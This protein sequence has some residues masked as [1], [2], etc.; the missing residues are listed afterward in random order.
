MS[1][2]TIKKT[3]LLPVL[4]L[5]ILTAC[6]GSSRGTQNAS[7]VDTSYDQSTERE[8]LVDNHIN[9]ENTVIDEKEERAEEHSMTLVEA[10]ENFDF[11]SV[12]QLRIDIDIANYLD[13]QELDRAFLNV[14]RPLGETIDLNNCLI[15]ST[16][17]TG[18][19]Y[20]ELPLANDITELAIEIRFYTNSLDPLS[21]RWTGADGDTWIVR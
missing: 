14:C 9:G 1:N 5:C 6:G 17:N 19:F 15:R 20:G 8:V 2:I 11:S 12:S 3:V 4:S 18:A 21:Y 7:T 13:E 10:D 16:L